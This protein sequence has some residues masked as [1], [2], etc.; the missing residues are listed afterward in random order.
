M[1]GGQEKV[2]LLHTQG[3]GLCK[4]SLDMATR[5]NQCLG[6]GEGKDKGK[7]RAKCRN[8]PNPHPSDGPGQRKAD[9]PHGPSL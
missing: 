9:I 4:S 3:G 8:S 7:M 2:G 6:P 5:I 1:K